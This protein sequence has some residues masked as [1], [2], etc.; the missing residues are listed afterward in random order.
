MVTP[1]VVGEHYLLT[2][3]TSGFT[4]TLTT[5]TASI[6]GVTFDAI[7]QRDVAGVISFRFRAT[8][9][10]ALTFTP[11]ATG[12]RVDLDNVSLKKITAGDLYVANNLDVGGATTFKGNVTISTKNIVTDTTTGT[13]FGTATNQKIGFFNATP[14]VQVGATIDLGV[15]LSNLGLRAAG[16]AYPLTTSGAINFTGNF[17]HNT[18]TATFSNGMTI[19]DARNIAL[20]TTTGT[21][22]GTATNQKLAFFNA[23]PVVQQTELT[24]ELTTITCSA[25]VT[26][27]YAIADLTATSPYGF[28]SAD[29]GQT[30]LKVI[31]NLQTRVNELETKLVAL[32]LL[33]DAD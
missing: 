11:S 9:T 7:K 5:L 18:G 4:G 24:D 8:T 30:V 15:V 22:I 3:T 32:G 27:D 6:G 31:A 23:T 20:N 2:F 29:E 26:P 25:P 19:A 17:T 21:K 28:V 16:T 13:K 14:I 1:I 12:L 10:D 33:A